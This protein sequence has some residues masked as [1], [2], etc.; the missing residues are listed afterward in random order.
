MSL[1]SIPG[2]SASNHDFLIGLS[3]VHMGRER[4]T[5]A[6]ASAEQA[7]EGWQPAHEAVEQAIHLRSK[8]TEGV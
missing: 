6:S 8:G 2:S 7:R 3:Y 5:S 1:S 4:E